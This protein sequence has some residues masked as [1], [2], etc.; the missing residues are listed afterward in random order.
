MSPVTSSPTT[1]LI[2]LGS[3][4]GDSAAM[5][6]QAF[7]KL[8]EFS[9]VPI[10]KSSLITTAPVDCP[11]GSPPFVN[12]AVALIPWPGETAD[13][14]VMKLF[15]LEWDLG[16][17]PKTVMNEARLIDLDLIAFGAEV[18]NRPTL[19]LPH[20]RAHLRRFVLQPLSEVAPEFVLP[21]QTRSVAELLQSLGPV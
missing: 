19:M 12:A 14:L 16:R 3:N 9:A 13:S 20:P 10:R 17:R 4:L 6:R 5:I 11:P 18:R 2:A 7:D 8:Q 15:T 1:A 21:G